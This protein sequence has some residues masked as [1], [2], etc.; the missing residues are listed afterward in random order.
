MKKLL[1]SLANIFILLSIFILSNHNVYSQ[2]VVDF[3]TATSGNKTTYATATVILNG[4]QWQMTEG[5]IGNLAEDKKTGSR[6]LR[7]RRNGTVPGVAT[8]LSDKLNGVGTISFQYARYGTESGQPS[9]FVEYS[10]NGG[11]TWI[12]AG[13]AIT[14][15]PA[16]LTTWS[17]TINQIGSVRIRFRTNTGGT[18]QRRFNIDNITLTNYSPVC[19]QP[20][21]WITINAPTEP[22][23]LTISTCTYAGEYNTI[24]NLITGQTY[25]FNSSVGGDWLVLTD[26]SNNILTSGTAPLNW[27]ANFNGTVRLHVSTN[28]LCGTQSVC[29]TT[30][31]TCTSCVP[32]PPGPCIQSTAFATVSAPINPT[33]LII[34]SC[35]YASEYNTITNVVIGRTY[36]FSSS[37]GTDW[38]TLT[39]V[40]NN[41]LIFGTSSISW[42]ATFSGTVRLH[43]SASASCSTQSVCRT[44][45]V[46]CTSC[47]P[48]PTISSFTPS[49]VCIN[50]NVSVIITGTNFNGTTSVNF[51]G[52]PAQSFTVNNS[53]QITAIVGNGTTGTIAVTTYSGTATSSGILSVNTLPNQ[54]SIING[55]VNICYGTTQNYSVTNVNGV[56]YNWVVPSGWLINSGQGSSSVNITA[57]GLS[58]SIS[59]TPSNSCGNGATRSLNVIVNSDIIVDYSGSPFVFC[60]DNT[61]TN[62]TPSILGSPNS[63]SISPALPSGLLFNSSNGIISGNPTVS[64]LATTYTI[65]ATNGT[66]TTSTSI[67][68]STKSGPNNVDAGLDETICV[69]SSLQLFGSANVP[70][71]FYNVDFSSLTGWTTNDGN[72]W[73]VTNSSNAGGTP[74]ELYFRYSTGSNGTLI[75]ANV[76][77]PLL[78]AT[79]W[80]ELTLSFKHMVDHFT[81]TIGPL[82]IETSLDGN[83][84]TPRWTISPNSNISS[85]T[86]S[87]IDLSALDGETF[88]IRFRHNGNIWNIDFWYIDDLEITGN[89]QL[90]YSWSPTAGLSNANISNPIITP[91]STTNYTLTATANGC[92][93]S[94]SVLITVR[95]LPIV[96]I[97]ATNVS[98]FGSSNGIIDL[99]VTGGTSPYTYNW[100][101][102][103]TDEDLSNLVAGTYNV[104]IT[105]LNGCSITENVTITQPTSDL[106]A[107][108]TKTNVLCF[109]NATGTVNLTVSGGTSPYTYN[110]SN[111]ATTEDLSSLTAG[112]YNVIITDANNC[113][114]TASVTITQPASGLTANITQTNVLIYGDTTGVID[115]TVSG[116]ISPYSYSWSNGATTED[117]SNLAAGV[118]SITVTDA[119][120][121]QLIT[122]VTIEEPINCIVGDI[123]GAQILCGYSQASYTVAVSQCFTSYYWSMPQ[124]MT[125]IDTDVNVSGYVSVDVFIDQLEF[126]SGNIVFTA[127]YNGGLSAVTLAVGQVPFTPEFLTT[128]TCGIPN[129]TATFEV[130]NVIGVDSYNWTQPN[131]SSLLYGQNTDSV[132]VKYGSL[133]NSGMLSVVA[134][135]LC[136]SSPAAEFFVLAPPAIPNN[137]QGSTTICSIEP[138]QLYYVDSVANAS[139]YIWGMPNGATII[140]NPTTN[141]SVNVMFQNFS[142]GVISV[143]SANTCGSSSMKFLTVSAPSIGAPSGISGPQ[144]VCSY[145]GTGQIINY[146]TPTVAGITNYIWNMPSGAT[147]INGL[148][149]NTVGI[150]FAAGFTGG[151]IGVSLSNGCSLSQQFIL[152]LY[153]VSTSTQLIAINGLSNVCSFIGTGSTVYSVTPPVGANSYEWSVP[154]GATIISGLG[155]SSITVSFASSFQSGSLSVNIST[156]CGTTYQQSKMLSKLPAD[157][158]AIS[159]PNCISIGSSYTYSIDAV[160]GATSYQWTIPSNATITSGQGTSSIVIQYLTSFSGG[161]ITVIP[162]NSCGNGQASSVSAI[163]LAPVVPS[164]IFGTTS[165]C[166]GQTLTYYVTP[167]PTATYYI[168]AV[169]VGMTIVGYQYGDS[170]VVSVDNQ[171]I[172]GLISCKSV[173][174]CGSS[175]MRYSNIIS[176]GNCSTAIIMDTQIEQQ[177]ITNNLTKEIKNEIDSTSN[178][179]IKSTIYPNPVTKYFH[180]FIE[181]APDVTYTI[182]IRSSIGQVVYS[183]EHKQH[184]LIDILYLSD[185]LY[186]VTIMNSQGKLIIKTIVKH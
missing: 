98:C 137:I 156:V 5:L 128:S 103:S 53:N 29:R 134:T 8:M 18:N 165:V 174:D 101:N 73:S 112:N 79:N 84:W 114:T 96:N 117:L 44:T 12:Q 167:V 46:T 146:S 172:S 88:Y 63:F 16:N 82:S 52:T 105:D 61:I 85:T 66:C 81:G 136:G 31:V 28:N 75:D 74:N 155:T 107:N 55:N 39:D 91:T 17:A 160:T 163:G 158:G 125:I 41:S 67:I 36:E 170:I 59:V 111:G 120:G 76:T 164:Q 177:I 186:Y 80:S 135:N 49:S 133:F 113:T 78:D 69:G 119:N 13:T 6:S 15:F 21:A 60:L 144:L 183:A 34:S 154:N 7:M 141:D 72:R 179:L 109:G 181:D 121:C 42:V 11:S 95:P 106:T 159:G 37:V 3:E 131:L 19:T 90:N 140:S 173:N 118:Y 23:P 30:S 14:S 20:T 185:G 127:V 175:P 132:R 10:V 97:T 100:S 99:T 122:S 124:G 168:W 116:G 32:P 26:A 147:I 2:Y 86:V 153:G 115:L 145:A 68:I 33:P 108:I 151:N 1:N 50:S 176:T 4:I 92:S 47:S 22:T 83:N 25:E 48:P 35:T 143:K 70:N 45:T 129:T 40:S 142:S 89:S 184:E 94:D 161:N 102:V 71:L 93:V 149:T 166:S 24:N 54:P 104:I 139:Y 38:L 169:P 162:S 87:N 77:S 182:K 178:S 9:L 27:T 43:V 150:Q 62:I 58:G 171:F 152:Q 57:N 130:V 123:E 126:T 64:S 110:W 148:G 51:G 180:F 157:A 138:S 56:N 65:T